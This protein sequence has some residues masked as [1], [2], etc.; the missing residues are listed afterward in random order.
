MCKCSGVWI[1]CEYCGLVGAKTPAV[2]V[3]G[4]TKAE[5]G[6]AMIGTAAEVL[7]SGNSLGQ[8]CRCSGVWIPCERCRRIGAKIQAAIVRASTKEEGALIGTAA[9]EGQTKTTAWY[10]CDNYCW[11]EEPNANHADCVHRC[12]N[13]PRRQAPS[14]IAS[15]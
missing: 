4:S 11:E 10:D 5:D 12:E 9:V 14:S 13:A 2:I 6:G 7:A 3:R 15:T 8:R 1:P